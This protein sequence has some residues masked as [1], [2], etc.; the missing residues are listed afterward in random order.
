MTLCAAAGLIPRNNWD[1][2]LAA[3]ITATSGIRRGVTHAPNVTRLFQTEPV[4]TNAGRVSLYAI[5]RGLDLPRGAEVGV[6]LFCCSVVFEAVRQAGLRPRFIDSD[7]EDYNLSVEDL[8]R[9]RDGLAAIVPVHMFGVPADM[10][11]ISAAAGGVPVI[12]DCAQSIFST[13][14]G[15]LT[16]S[17]SMVSFFSFRCGKYISAGE[18][19]AIICADPELRGRIAQLT[20]SFP[21][22]STPG[23]LVDTLTTLGKATMYSRPWYGLAGYPIGTRLDRRLNLTAKDGFQTGQI[24]ATQLALIDRRI[25]GFQEKVDRQRRHAHVLLGALEPGGFQ[26]PSER[27]DRVRN[28]FQFPLRFASAGQRDQM[29]RHLL[30]CGIDTARYLDDIADVARGQY[31]Y[32]GDCPTAESLSRTTLLVPIHY[33]LRPQDVQHVAVSINQGSRVL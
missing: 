25:G 18:G 24:A 32:G 7:L 12:E 27:P 5:L 11:A 19:S 1:Y 4:W 21:R 2:G 17:L 30:A 33:T 9:K 29:A 15:G 13:Y 8:Q 22:W 26:L 28:W 14:K 16:G 31:G 23:M 3:V 10:D 20:A 6:P